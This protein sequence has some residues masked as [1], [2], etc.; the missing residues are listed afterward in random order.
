M[1]GGDFEA[2]AKTAL[3]TSDPERIAAFKE[4]IMACSSAEEDGEYSDEEPASSPGM[5]K[6]MMSGKG[7]GLAAL[8]GK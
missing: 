6:E 7:K 4:A 2:F 5:G 8:F 3:G 1:A